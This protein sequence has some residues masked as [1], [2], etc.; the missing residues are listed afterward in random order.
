MNEKKKLSV[1]QVV[2]LVLVAI[3]LL[4]FVQGIVFALRDRNWNSLWGKLITIIILGVI[5]FIL[6]DRLLGGWSGLLKRREATKE[7][8]EK[9]KGNIS[10][11][12][13]AIFSLTWSREIYHG[14]PDDRKPLV[15]TSF[16][17]IGIAGGIVML[18]LGR[19]GFLDR[20]QEAGC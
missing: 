5:A 7:H 15:K 14:I 16:I 20:V 6:W 4:N 9:S 12:D 13:A 10:I 17:L 8:F 2:G 18:D 3:I 19:Y 11:K 1:P